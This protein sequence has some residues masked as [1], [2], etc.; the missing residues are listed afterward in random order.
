MAIVTGASSGIGKAIAVALVEEGLQ[1][2]IY[3]HQCSVYCILDTSVSVLTICHLSSSEKC[4]HYLPIFVTRFVT[5]G[6]TGS[7]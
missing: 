2:N 4:K 1:V 3:L 6:S 7:S 5:G